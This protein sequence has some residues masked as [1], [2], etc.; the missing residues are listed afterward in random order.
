[1]AYVYVHKVHLYLR[2]SG[3]LKGKRNELSSLKADLSKQFAAA[4]SEVGFQEL[5]QRSDLVCVLAGP[6]VDEL[7]RRSDAMKRWLFERHGE[8]ATL[9]RSLVSLEDI[10]W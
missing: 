8:A 5:W 9:E 2:E 4:V 10:Q 6:S 7:R 3:S 1:M